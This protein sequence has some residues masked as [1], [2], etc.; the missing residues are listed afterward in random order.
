MAERLGVKAPALY[1]HV[2]SIGDLQHRIATLAMTE[3]GD[4]LRDTLHGQIRGD[5]FRAP[6]KA[7]QSYIAEHPGRYSAVNAA[8][9]K[10]SNDLLFAAASRV[11]HGPAQGLKGQPRRRKGRRPTGHGWPRTPVRRPPDFV[12]LGWNGGQLSS[13]R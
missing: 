2:D 5:A 7:M 12:P 4:A 10:A 9:L 13:R 8:P 3:F 6:F 1:K 11:T